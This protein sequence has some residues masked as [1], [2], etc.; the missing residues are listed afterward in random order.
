[1]LVWFILMVPLFL[2]IVGLAIDGGLVF[3]A[4]RE[5]QNSADA[6]ARAGGAEVDL[7]R[8]RGSD[9]TEVTLDTR[10][11]TAAASGYVSGQGVEGASIGASP[12]G[13][14]VTLR[15]QVPLSF[16]RLVG[17]GTVT[18]EATASAAPFYGI[19]S[20]QRP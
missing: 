13:I 17:L 1:M 6:A 7:E 9:G 15:R 5:L 8:L 3:A 10:L 18:I 4:R 12:G 16:L 20:G 19:D 2:A 14:T 11:A